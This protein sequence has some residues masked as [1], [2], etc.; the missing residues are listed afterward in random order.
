ME[1]N[2][3]EGR[4]RGSS[5]R[6]RALTL[7]GVSTLALSGMGG[8]IFGASQAF[9]AVP[10]TAS[11]TSSSYS[12]GTGA[13]GNL[14]VSS[15]NNIL[16]K[17]SIYTIN[18]TATD[19]LAAGANS[20]TLTFSDAQ[21][22]TV[23]GTLLD[24]STGTSQAVS[25][26]GA[27]AGASTQITLN[28]AVTAG[29][30]VQLTIPGV[31]QGSATDISNNVAI[32]NATVTVQTTLD[33]SPVKSA[34]YTLAA[35]AAAA[36]PTATASPATQGSTATWTLGSF[37]VYNSS[38]TALP[39]GS[40][41]T[42]T[43]PGASVPTLPLSDYTIT[44]TPSSGTATTQTP[45]SVTANGS[46]S[47]TI[48][49]ATGTAGDLTVGD[50]ITL[51]VAGVT[52][53]TA[54]SVTPTL[55]V[56]TPSSGWTI[57]DPG[58]STT[59]TFPAV[60]I[61]GSTTSVTSAS[62]S[63][64]PAYASLSTGSNTSTYTAQFTS[65]TALATTD[66]VTVQLAPG[67]TIN[68]ASA[69][70]PVII[71][72]LTSG[73]TAAV[74]STTP[75]A[76]SSPSSVTTNT[77]QVATG[78]SVAKGDVVSVQIFGVTNPTTTGTLTGQ[79]FTTQDSVPVSASYSLVLPSTT[80][81]KITVS[82]SS[83]LAGGSATYTITNLNAGSSA[84]AA[85]SSIYIGTPT[86]STTQWPTVPGNYMITDL[87]NSASSAAA[88]TV[89][90][91]STSPFFG[92]VL[93]TTNAI[94][95]NDNLT[96][97]IS[98]V[99]NPTGGSYTL[100]FSPLISTT[101]SVAPPTA[102]NAAATAANGSLVN[103]GGTI[104]VYA[105]GVAFGIPTPADYTAIA[106]SLGNP[107]VVSATSVTTSGTVRNGTLLQVVGSPEIGVVSGGAYYP[108][109]T[110]QQFTSEGYSWGKVIE[111]PSLGSVTMGSGTPPNAAS[112]EADGALVNVSGT[113][114]VYAGGVAFG[115]PTLADFTAISAA[116]GNPMVVSAS[117]VTTT[118]SMASGT[119]VQVVGSP[120]I[121]VVTSSGTQAGFATA[122]EF[123]ADGYSFGRVILI[124]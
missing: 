48:T 34:E 110:A 96:I 1:S 84:L 104:Y 30:A 60:T 105:G 38:A 79:V 100:N 66:K 58:T 124:P 75:S 89:T 108:F 68:A 114:Y 28:S 33:S 27:A 2:N 92:V 115:I 32:T 63:P 111:V 67:T 74:T 52:N 94:N 50:T 39:G 29:H 98:G 121:N 83:T 97:T 78:I 26:T 76:S 102:P 3:L 18:F 56:T 17:T 42:L 8:A 43:I 64:S 10:T 86:S 23:T 87:T 106:T 53:P 71:T 107:T 45:S 6:R 101:V 16:N 118:G 46:G 85:G 14:T 4:S 5:F 13:V 11:G 122:S 62:I 72:D 15:T 24:S 88:A 99:I 21:T 31:T 65:T 37:G 20:I 77:V 22:S 55:A 57:V 19:G 9:A 112:T 49:T 36:K 103:V 123:L 35:A 73:A 70:N 61:S 7:V 109:A 47:V 120:Q 12:V 80:S 117:S 116:L 82:L 119:L 59:D 40:V 54:A 44:D 91:V 90:T 93:T 41:F 51:T 25:V 81:G 95:A 113:I 69:T